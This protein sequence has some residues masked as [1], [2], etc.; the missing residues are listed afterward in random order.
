MIESHGSP[1]DPGLLTAPRVAT[2]AGTGGTGN[3]TV[4]Q[5]RLAVTA[6]LNDQLNKQCKKTR[7]PKR[8]KQRN[9]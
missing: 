7:M 2:I 4:E 6:W 1:R 9:E 8:A 5:C 3:G